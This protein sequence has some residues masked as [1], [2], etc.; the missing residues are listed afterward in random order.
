MGKIERSN[1]TLCDFCAM[2]GKIIGDL[3]EDDDFIL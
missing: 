2:R 3:F 1:Y